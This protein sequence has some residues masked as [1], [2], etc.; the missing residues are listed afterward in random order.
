MYQLQCYWRVQR[1]HRGLLP[2]HCSDASLPNGLKPTAP[3]QGAASNTPAA[4][5][6]TLD[7]FDPFSTRVPGATALD[8]TAALSPSGAGTTPVAAAVDADTDAGAGSSSGSSGWLIL[9]VVAVTSCVAK[10]CFFLSYFLIK[11]YIMNPQGSTNLQGGGR[12]QGGV[13]VCWAARPGAV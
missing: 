9:V 11:I 5:G 3:S 12:L 4:F 7:P 13:L 2:R 8:G 10:D 6:T 1:V